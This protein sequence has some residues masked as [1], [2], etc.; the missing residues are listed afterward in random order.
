MNVREIA[1][2]VA[3]SP[4]DDM[5]DEFDINGVPDFRGEC[6][7][8]APKDDSPLHRS[9]RKLSLPTPGLLPS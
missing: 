9:G 4:H 5:D 2:E 1:L 3:S 8:E 6:V 7:T